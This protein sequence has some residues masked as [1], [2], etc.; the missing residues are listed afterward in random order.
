MTLYM[1]WDDLPFWYSE[2][3]P[4][5]K[6]EFKAMASDQLLA[7]MADPQ[8]NQHKVALSGI[9]TSNVL[10]LAVPSNG[11]RKPQVWT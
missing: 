4:R 3:M 5:T 1:D 2:Y 9:Y 8:Y 10:P 6:N 7:T 11:E